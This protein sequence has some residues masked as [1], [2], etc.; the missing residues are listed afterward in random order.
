MIDDENPEPR[1]F[2]LSSTDPNN[3]KTVKEIDQSTVNEIRAESVTSL[4]G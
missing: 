1:F 2:C 4:R 3:H